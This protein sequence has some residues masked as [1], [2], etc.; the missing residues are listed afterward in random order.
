MALEKT[1]K[2]IFVGAVASPGCEPHSGGVLTACRSLLTSRFSSE[3][4]ILPVDSTARSFPPEHLLSRLTKALLR[5]LKF[6]YLSIVRRPAAA[7]IFCSEGPSFFEKILMC[8]AGRILRVRCYLSVRAGPFM[9]EVEQSRVPWLYRW[10]LSV[11]SMLVCQSPSWIEF[12]QSIRL[13][14]TKCVVI[15]NWIDTERYSGARTRQPESAA[16]TFLYIGWLVEYK[17]L[18]D[19]LQAVTDVHKLI[20]DARWILVG[21]GTDEVRLRQLADKQGIGDKVEFAGWQNHD[22]VLE[23]LKR[24]DVFV[25]PSHTEGFPNALLEAMSAGLP[26]ITTEVGGIPGFI[27]NGENG[28]LVPPG[29]P[30]RLADAM[31]E[32]AK[33][34]IL[35]FKLG[36]AALNHVRCV[37]EME[38]VLGKL[39]AALLARPCSIATKQDA[40]RFRQLPGEPDPS[41][42]R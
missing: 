40:E 35:R 26:V 6:S 42:L 33:D 27:R 9:N 17:G 13:D 22:N 19:L 39:E 24:S 2:L 18:Y 28:L 37:H 11:P 34:P 14:T 16:V 21:G 12:Y 32:I 4:E 31:L 25:L 38:E 7:L 1:R 20:P 8:V 41:N 5:I 3:W 10:L 36:S 29:A 30:V 15:P 23:Y